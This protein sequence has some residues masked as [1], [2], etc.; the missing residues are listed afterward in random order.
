VELLAGPF[1]R[2]LASKVCLW[3]AKTQTRSI[4]PMQ[5]LRKW[6]AEGRLRFCVAK[7]DA[8]P[9]V[10]DEAEK[11]GTI[12]ARGLNVGLSNVFAGNGT[13]GKGTRDP[14]SGKL[15][16]HEA[17][18]TIASVVVTGVRNDPKLVVLS[19]YASSDADFVD[20]ATRDQDL[21]HARARLAAERDD[22]VAGAPSVVDAASTAAIVRT[23]GSHLHCVV[24]SVST[25]G[26]HAVC[27]AGAPD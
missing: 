7:P 24:C 5:T 1:R 3:D 26:D 11:E 4:V 18:Y 15:K 21:A 13:C 10:A 22:A 16:L 27:A 19:E 6:H 23:Q 17:G 8:Y 14:A 2:G 9:S 20:T 12:E 25:D